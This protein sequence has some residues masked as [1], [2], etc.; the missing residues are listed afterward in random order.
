MH[1]LLPIASR[2]GFAAAKGVGIAAGM[3]GQRRAWRRS[4]P[5]TGAS[6][7]ADVEPPQARGIGAR[8]RRRWSN[9]R[10]STRLCRRRDDSFQTEHMLAAGSIV[11]T[12]A[13]P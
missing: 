13:A 12:T 3:E 1:H 7:E 9:N 5:E 10:S 11:I 4:A 2:I 6:I 8:F